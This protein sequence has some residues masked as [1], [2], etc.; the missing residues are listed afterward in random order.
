MRITLIG[1]DPESN[2]TGS[3]TIYRT[4]RGSWLV[5]GWEVTDADILAMLN[6]PEGESVVEIPDRM[7]QFFRAF[8]EEEARAAGRV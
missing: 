2:P 4:D 6:I 7:I 5:Q 8:F 1:K 3:P